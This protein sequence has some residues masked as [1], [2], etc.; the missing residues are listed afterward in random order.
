MILAKIR[1]SQ[2]KIKEAADIMQ[3]VQV[4]TY[5]AME[6]REKTEFIL[7]QVRLCL[8]SGDFIRAQIISR[9]INTKIL[10]DAGFEVRKK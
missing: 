5:G 3:E 4:E 9:K 10:N 2:G 8:D 7:E 1:E 6:K